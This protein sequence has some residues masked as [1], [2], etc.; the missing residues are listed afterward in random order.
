MGSANSTTELM[1][2]TYK[3]VSISACVP[4]ASFFFEIKTVQI[5]P[6]LQKE[7]LVNVKICYRFLFFL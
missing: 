6:A 1:R 5:E 7:K 3:T 4:E 2:L